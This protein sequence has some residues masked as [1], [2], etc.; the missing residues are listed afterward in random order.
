[1]KTKLCPQMASGN[2]CSRGPKCS[3]A[4]GSH[5]IRDRPHLV[6]TKL[7][8]DVVNGRVCTRPDCNYAH[9][10][11][12][13]NT[14]STERLENYKT[15]LCFFHTNHQSGD[16]PACKYGSRCRFAHGEDELRRSPNGLNGSLWERVKRCDTTD[17]ATRHVGDDS[18][19]LSMSFSSNDRISLAD[20]I[21]A[22]KFVGC[23]HSNESEDFL[24]NSMDEPA[25]RSYFS[26]RPLQMG[27]DRHA[28]RQ[29][30]ATR[31]SLSSDFDNC[32]E[33]RFGV[34]ESRK[35]FTPCARSE[36]THYSR[37]RT[38]D[39]FDTLVPRPNLGETPHNCVSEQLELMK[40]ELTKQALR[41]LESEGPTVVPLLSHWDPFCF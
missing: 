26:F 2:S 22:S 33:N 30:I 34:I 9:A 8:P 5:E 14:T 29:R 23:G 35:G 16:G 21:I 41:S 12:E 37:M 32:I 15:I 10:E 11:E 19:S 24:R 27:S 7:C 3:Y 18:S 31:R 38:P 4:H 28:S 25:T 36:L 20:A 17:T 39:A 1:M 6:K 40:M 13:L